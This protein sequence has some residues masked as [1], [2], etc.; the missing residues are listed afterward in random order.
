MLLLLYMSALRCNSHLIFLKSCTCKPKNI[1]YFGMDTG[2]Q[3]SNIASCFCKNILG[4]IA[5]IRYINQI[6]HQLGFEN[7]VNMRSQI[8]D[9]QL[10]IKIHTSIEIFECN[11]TDVLTDFFVCNLSLKKYWKSTCTIKFTL[12]LL[13]CKELLVCINLHRQ[14]DNVY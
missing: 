13:T 3:P 9:V 14:L 11:K 5:R 1:L 12:V 8:F 4:H 2:I 10:L 7:Y 6:W